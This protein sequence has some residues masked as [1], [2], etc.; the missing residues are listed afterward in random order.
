M[1]LLDVSPSMVA[2]LLV[3]D[4]LE[5]FWVHNLSSLFVPNVRV[6]ACLD[7]LVGKPPAVTVC[8]VH[9]SS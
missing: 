4:E 3:V 6:S 5:V 8:I 1:M 9:N 2:G 7:Y